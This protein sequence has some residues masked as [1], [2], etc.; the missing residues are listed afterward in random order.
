MML[1]VNE[2]EM[3]K[4]IKTS[5]TDLSTSTPGFRDTNAVLNE[6]TNMIWGHQGPL[7]QK[8]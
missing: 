4:A 3:V 5:H 1:Q 7:F 8:W 2:H 6:V